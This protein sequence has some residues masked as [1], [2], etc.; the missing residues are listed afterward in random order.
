[1]RKGSIGLNSA[2]SFLSGKRS[3]SCANGDN[4]PVTVKRIVDEEGN[5]MP[6]APHPK[7]VF[8]S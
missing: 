7:Q 2:T 4:I 8:I 5:D 1:M 3:R 6:S